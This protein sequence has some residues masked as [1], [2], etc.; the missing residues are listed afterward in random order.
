GGKGLFGIFPEPVKA[1][2]YIRDVLPITLGAPLYVFSLAGILLSIVT[3][4]KRNLI[5][6]LAILPFWIFLER[7]RYHPLRFSLTMMPA[8]CLM[9]AYFF[10][11]LLR[12]RL[13]IITVSSRIALAAVLIYS[14]L[15]SY[16]F[17]QVL[18]VKNDIRYSVDRW[19]DAHVRD[20]SQIAML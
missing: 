17:I 18:N 6:L 15:Y 12:S 2:L 7:L 4:H 8:L 11:T 3:R 19:I 1:P 9:A 10:D 13:K 20:K 16:A 14:T 5:L